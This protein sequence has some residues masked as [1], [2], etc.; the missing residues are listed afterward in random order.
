[1][2]SDVAQL[3]RLVVNGGRAFDSAEGGG[4]GRHAAPV[5][6]NRS[7][8]RDGLGDLGDLRVAQIGAIADG[9]LSDRVHLSCHPGGEDLAALFLAET[10]AWEVAFGDKSH[11]VDDHLVLCEDG[12]DNDRHERREVPF[13][14][15]FHQYDDEP[16]GLEDGTAGWS[17]DDGTQWYELDRSNSP[18]TRNDAPVTFLDRIFDVGREVTQSINL[19]GLPDTAEHK[20]DL[21]LDLHSAGSDRSADI[22]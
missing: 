21:H 1:M 13:S 12:V 9:K 19:K 8:A 17:A 4:R 5:S 16:A 20:Q 18:S 22:V 15:Y 2:M 11:D 10:R 3:G 7:Q 14:R 6:S